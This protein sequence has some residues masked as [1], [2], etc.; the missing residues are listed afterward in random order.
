MTHERGVIFTR[1]QSRHVKWIFA[2]SL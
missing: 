2:S 1:S